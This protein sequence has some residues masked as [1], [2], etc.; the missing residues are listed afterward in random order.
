MSPSNEQ[1]LIDYLDNTLEGSDRLQAEKLIRED[2]AAA[3]ELADLQFSVELIREVG[4]LEQVQEV[5]KSFD[6]SAKVVPLQKKETGAVVRSLSKNV[7]R[8]AAMIVLVLGALSVHKYAN[9]TTGS[10]YNDNFSS[11]E[12]SGSRGAGNDGD[13]E[14][15]YRN[16][17]WTGVENAFSLQT[18]K[19][20]KSWFLAGMA[21]MEQKKYDQ[22]ITSFAEAININR[23]S[24]D[25]VYQD[26]AEYYQ[27]LAY[28]AAKNLQKVWPFLKKSGAIK[29]I[30][31]I[32][33]HRI[34]I[35]L[36]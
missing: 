2:T 36:I 3:K 18:V 12:L 14:K 20:A 30:S 6:A 10:V 23:N 15:A 27:A 21:D 7:F 34:S 22:A 19:T 25:P 28:L 16:K 9:T 24:A 11:Y 31:F 13:L 32:K 33:K 17:N 26:E 35:P 29:T 1:I 5:R 4:V 8:V